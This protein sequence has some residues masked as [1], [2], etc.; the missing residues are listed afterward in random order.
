MSGLCRCPK[1]CPAGYTLSSPS[2]TKTNTLHVN[3]PSTPIITNLASVNAYNCTCKSSLVHHHIN[4]DTYP[5][6]SD[7]GRQSH[8]FDSQGFISRNSNVPTRV[9]H[10]YSFADQEQIHIDLPNRL[11]ESEKCNNNTAAK[12]K[13]LFTSL[14]MSTD[15]AIKQFQ[16]LISSWSCNE[17][18]CL[19]LEYEALYELQLLWK[20]AIKTRSRAPTLMVVNSLV[21]AFEGVNI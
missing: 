7:S 17:L 2:R 10:P 12:K 18:C 8:C 16:N 3:E 11:N 19:Y 15:Y 6:N 4:P 21:K 5:P 13:D 14:S 1:K 20:E 9:T